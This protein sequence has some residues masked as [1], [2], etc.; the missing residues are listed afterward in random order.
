[1]SESLF[2][3]FFLRTD[4]GCKTSCYAEPVR[5]SLEVN[6][7]VHRDAA[8]AEQ[9]LEH[10]VRELGGRESGMF[11]EQGI[12]PAS[13]QSMPGHVVR[14][15]EFQPGIILEKVMYEIFETGEAYNLSMLKI[16][17]QLIYYKSC[18]NIFAFIS[19]F[20]NMVYTIDDA[21]DGPPSIII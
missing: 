4:I 14:F 21:S 19:L 1:M 3:P 10:I 18:F 9:P 15:D 5:P 12:I 11:R 13:H 8:Q 20:F 7:T 17:K 16:K 2:H 6:V